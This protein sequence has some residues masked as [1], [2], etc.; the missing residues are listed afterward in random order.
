VNLLITKKITCI[1]SSS[2]IADNVK[3]ILTSACRGR[4][5]MA[6]YVERLKRELLRLRQK[7][8]ETVKRATFLG[9]TGAEW[10]EYDARQFSLRL[11]AHQLRRLLRLDRKDRAAPQR[12]SLER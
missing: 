10:R 3:T 9:M 6:L 11:L 1:F 8:L 5:E 12:G 7:Q 2:G 4:A